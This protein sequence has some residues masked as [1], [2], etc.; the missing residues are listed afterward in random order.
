MTTRRTLLRAILLESLVPVAQ[1]FPQSGS[2]EPRSLQHPSGPYAVGRAGFHWTDPNRPDRAATDPASHRE[3]MVYLW[4]PASSSAATSRAPYLPGA[5]EMDADPALQARMRDEFGAYWPSIVS[6]A[7]SSNA[8]EGAQVIAKPS[9][10]PVV[11]FSHGNGSTGFDYT[12]LIEDLASHGFVVAVIEHTHIAVAVRFPDGRV[13]PF[14]KEKFPEGLSRAERFERMMK[15]A[16]AGIAEGAADVGF[17]KAR[18]AE[19]NDTD[20]GQFPLAGRLDLKHIV[21][22]GHSAGGAIATRACQ[23][24]SGL[25]ACA[26]LDG[27]MPPVA[28]LPVFPDRAVMKQPL[29]LVE[30][31]TTEHSVAATKEQLREYLQKKEQQ[32]QSC[33]PGTYHVTLTA[34][35]IAHPSFSDTP[36]FFAGSQ[37]YP[38]I[39]AVRHNHVLIQSVVRA[40]LGKTFKGTKAPL[41]DGPAQAHPEASVQR[42]GHL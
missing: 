23:L 26:N 4:Y 38:P 40:F 42:Y 41:L 11:L 16:A 33:V 30:P 19:L 31:R 21:A 1:V 22:M 15:S 3:L 39:Q 32:L 24:D 35:G 20:H 2:D 25:A 27:G 14:H 37:G 36:I 7:F 18:L 9:R 12:S 6:G 5:K 17:V 29:L 13:V 34:P 28:V 8:S 10:L